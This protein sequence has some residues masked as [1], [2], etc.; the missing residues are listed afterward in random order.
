M[1]QNTLHCCYGHY[2]CNYESASLIL[3]HQYQIAFKDLSKLIICYWIALSLVS[4]L[5][6]KH[7]KAYF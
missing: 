4:V 3:Y 1:T 5:I 7:K 6:W 2:V